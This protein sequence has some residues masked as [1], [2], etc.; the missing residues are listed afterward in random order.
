MLVPAFERAGEVESV[1]IAASALEA[2]DATQVVRAF[3][4]FYVVF[5]EFMAL[6]AV[7]AF[8]D[9]EPYEEGRDAIE[10]RKYCT[11]RTQDSAPGSSRKKN[12]NKKQSE[13][14][15]FKCVWPGNLLTC[16]CLSS[17][18]RDGLF[19]RTGGTNTTYKETMPFTE[20]IRDDQHCSDEHNIADVSGPFGQF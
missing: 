16:N 14:C 7:C 18:I 12:G 11:E 8:I 1:K 19:Q 6:K 2:A 13:D 15:Q 10:Q 17:H 5:T 9:I 20:E 3:F 4:R